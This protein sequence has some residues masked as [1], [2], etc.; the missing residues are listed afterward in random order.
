MLLAADQLVNHAAKFRWMYN[1]QVRVPLIVRTPMGGKRGYGP[2]HSQTL[3]KHLLG[4]PDLRVLATRGAIASSMA[5]IPL[6]TAMPAPA[7]I[8]PRENLS[9]ANTAAGDSSTRFA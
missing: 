4:V 2:T 5:V 1:D 9:R 6:T 3:E 7:T 8:A